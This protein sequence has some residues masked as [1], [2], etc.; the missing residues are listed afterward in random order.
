MR[1]PR[2]LYDDSLDPWLL[3]VAS[4]AAVVLLAAITTLTGQP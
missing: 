2:I 1:I 4:L 3:L